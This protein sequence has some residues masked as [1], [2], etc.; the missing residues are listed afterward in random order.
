[1][2]ARRKPRTR[3]RHTAAL[4]LGTVAVSLFAYQG[5][6]QTASAEEYNPYKDAP[7]GKASLPLPDD[8]ILN[9]ANG[10]PVASH[11]RFSYV[12]PTAPENSLGLP[13]NVGVPGA[14]QTH[15]FTQYQ[16]APCYFGVPQS[17]PG[18][19]PISIGE[20]S[21][22]FPKVRELY[23]LAPWFEQVPTVA[24]QLNDLYGANT[25]LSD[26]HSNCPRQGVPVTTITDVVGSCL[27]HMNVLHFPNDNNASDPQYHVPNQVPL[28]AHSHIL[29][30]YVN[31]DTS[32]SPWGNLS[33][34]ESPTSLGATWWHPRSVQVLDRAIWPDAAG[35]CP[36]GREHC[37]T[38]IKALRE[39]QKNGQARAEGGS[40]ILLYFS[41]QPIDQAGL[42]TLDSISPNDA[43]GD[44]RP[45]NYALWQKYVKQN[46]NEAK[47]KADL[48][49]IG[50]KLA[51]SQ[52]KAGKAP[53]PVAP[54]D[55]SA[56][57]KVTVVRNDLV[58]A[59]KD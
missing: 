27:M 46:Y 53:L 20:I 52:E 40:N 25:P 56:S 22:A 23:G 32:Q 44:F 29:G 16:S 19:A 51:A 49:A 42:Q 9:Y 18:E 38:S 28:P 11:Y 15:D 34:K 2:F 10:Q 33:T 48:G 39:A 17:N 41:V 8:V 37:L 12:C 54:T 1:V 5:G 13:D 30:D 21:A 26:I 6:W 45:A 35:N 59:R 14:K 4:V 47:A 24:G 58:T 7:I 36:A 55:K 3:G 50:K 43:N 57:K 31:T